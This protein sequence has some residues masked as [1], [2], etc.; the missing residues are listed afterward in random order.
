MLAERDYASKHAFQSM[1]YP[2]DD[3]GVAARWKGDV[4]CDARH[5]ACVAHTCISYR[6]STGQQPVARPA[7]QVL[8]SLMQSMF[9]RSRLCDNVSTTASAEQVNGES[10]PG[11]D[12][13]GHS[14]WPQS[15][16]DGGTEAK[17]QALLEVSSSN[18]EW[19]RR[20]E[21]ENMILSIGTAALPTLKRAIEGDI[22]AQ[23]WVAA[24]IIQKIQK[25][26][27]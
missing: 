26:V 10:N 11:I 7:L 2:E 1:L 22:V 8:V 24:G 16:F 12:R 19:S 13:V 17:V 15:E 4:A 6:E 14:E 23:R 3:F 25:K 18:R 27:G 5:R 21:A 9:C 20:I